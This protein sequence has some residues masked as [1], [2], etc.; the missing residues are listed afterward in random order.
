VIVNGESRIA[1]DVSDRERWIM[2]RL[3]QRSETVPETAATGSPEPGQSIS[4]STEKSADFR[5]AGH[6]DF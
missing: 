6:A 5:G 4:G 3:G 1:W 2:K